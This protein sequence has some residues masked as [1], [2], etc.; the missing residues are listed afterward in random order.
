MQ[1]LPCPPFEKHYRNTEST[2]RGLC[3]SRICHE[4]LHSLTRPTKKSGSHA[5]FFRE[6]LIRKATRDGCSRVQQPEPI[7]GAACTV[8]SVRVVLTRRS[9][10]NASQTISSNPPKQSRMSV[11]NDKF[12]CRAR[13]IDPA[14]QSGKEQSLK[15]R[16]ET[17]D[18]L[19]RASR[20]RLASCICEVEISE[21]DRSK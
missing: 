3:S 11:S 12:L 14:T 13:I 17:G 7:S 19:F 15:E 2:L 1:P 20:N 9:D 21:C 16:C 8:R 6:V 18:P 5:V 10:A 4:E